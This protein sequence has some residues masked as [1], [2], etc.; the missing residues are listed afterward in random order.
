MKKLFFILT[1]AL[2]SCTANKQVVV[3]RQ[4]KLPIVLTIEPLYF[5]PIIQTELE[6]RGF[7]FEKKDI[8][9]QKV[10]DY[11]KSEGS[12]YF[13]NNPDKVDY[14]TV[15]TK[16]MEN[17]EP[18]YTSLNINIKANSDNLLIDSILWRVNTLPYNPRERPQKGYFVKPNFE[19]NEKGI[20]FIIDSII[21]S[22]ALLS[23]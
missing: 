15:K 10:M 22:G 11:I 5:A 9:R 8:A 16:L 1:L 19:I 18:M 4:E 12:N 17:A 23:K 13:S 6:S 2:I 7:E 3:S 14:E 20:K 21:S